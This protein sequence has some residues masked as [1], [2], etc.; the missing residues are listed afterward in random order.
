MRVT[1]HPRCGRIDR[2]RL[3]F[4]SLDEFFCIFFGKAGVCCQRRVEQS[5]D[6]DGNEVALDLVGY[7]AAVGVRQYRHGGGRSHDQGVAIGG[8]LGTRLHANHGGRSWAIFDHHRLPKGFGQLQCNFTCVCI[9][10][11]ANREWRNDL[12]GLVRIF[13]G[14]YG[15]SG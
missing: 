3:C 12:D 8:G 5:H 4:Q 15:E 13:L 10:S 6:A 9:R 7:F 11:R 1:A 14:L 2:S